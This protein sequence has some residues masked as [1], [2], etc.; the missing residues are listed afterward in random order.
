[1][2]RIWWLS[3][4][5][6]FWELWVSVPESLTRQQFWLPFELNNYIIATAGCLIASH[7]ADNP[8]HSRTRVRTRVT[9]ERHQFCVFECSLSFDK[10]ETLLVN[11]GWAMSVP[12]TLM[13][14]PTFIVWRSHPGGAPWDCQTPLQCSAA[15]SHT[16]RRSPRSIRALT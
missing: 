6:S 16:G 14:N 9:R 13:L 12:V 10:S 1:M 4:L 15:T 11:S 5:C 2:H 3:F 8:N 7:P